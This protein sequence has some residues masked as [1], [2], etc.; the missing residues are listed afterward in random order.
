MK[1]IRGWDYGALILN[2]E[3]SRGV[4]TRFKKNAVVL[5]AVQVNN[6]HEVQ[7]MMGRSSRNRGVCEGVLY[8]ETQ[9]KSISALN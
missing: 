1:E 8:F 2:A 5:I 7:Q 6:Y 4:D 3:E 9:E